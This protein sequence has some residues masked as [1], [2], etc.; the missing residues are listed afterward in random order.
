MGHLWAVCYG[1]AKGSAK[2]SPY[3]VG[4][5]VD[6]HRVTMEIDTGVAVS[7]MLAVTFKSSGR[8]DLWIQL[9]CSCVPT[10]GRRSQ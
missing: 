1:K 10:Q 5:D 7:L 3:S 6:G 8:V 2:S 4:V 9:W